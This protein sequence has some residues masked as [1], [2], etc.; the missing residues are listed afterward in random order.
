MTDLSVRYGTDTVIFEVTRERKKPASIRITVSDGGT[1]LVDAPLSSTDAEIRA[2]VRKRLRWISK[3]SSRGKQW[4]ARSVRKRYVSG[5]EHIYLG[6][7]YVLKVV[8][9]KP[10]E[11][12]VRLK[13][14]YLLVGSES[15]DAE[16]IRELLNKW[17]RMRAG[18]YLPGRL[19]ELMSASMRLGK[20]SPEIALRKMKSQ[21][22]SCSKSGKILVN[23]ALIR[24]PRDCIDYVLMHELCHLKHHNHG[25]DFYQLLGRHMPDWENRKNLLEQ[26]SASIL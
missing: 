1:I 5:E 19:S 9:V 8:T 24:A 2:A 13:G 16:T 6:R 17:Y 12:G 7:R 10:A 18:A 21:W 22:A 20:Q 14:R 4:A 15:S 3:Y 23:P 11:S 26:I 25:K